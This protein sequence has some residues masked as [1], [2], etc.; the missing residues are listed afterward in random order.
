MFRSE[1]FESAIFMYKNMFNIS[2]ASLNTWFANP[3]YYG[4]PETLAKNL[5]ERIGLS[6]LEAAYLFWT[7][8]VIC[9][10]FVSFFFPSSTEIF[11]SSKK[12]LKMQASRL[13]D[14]WHHK[15]YWK[16]S[17]SWRCYVACLFMICIVLMK[18]EVGF[19][20]FDF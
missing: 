2:N 3:L 8:A 20:Y 16:P 18:R 14:V 9:G 19:L 10:G 5:I 17:V 11:N 4:V 6:S 7:L 15:L 13:I 12:S 1:S